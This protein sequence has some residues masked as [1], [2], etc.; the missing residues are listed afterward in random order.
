MLH[1][2]IIYM[3][4]ESILAFTEENGLK[5]EITIRLLTTLM[6]GNTLVFH[7]CTCVSI[8]E[9]VTCYTITIIAVDQTCGQ[10]LETY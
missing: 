9:L 3:H 7:P 1:L 5:C 6:R 10:M 4:N 8:Y 2:C